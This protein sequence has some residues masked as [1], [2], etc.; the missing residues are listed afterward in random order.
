MRIYFLNNRIYVNPLVANPYPA[1]LQD[2][3]LFEK[4]G[5]GPRVGTAGTSYHY[6]WIEEVRLCPTDALNVCCP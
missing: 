1:K 6:G 5:N 4:W 3:E 2:K